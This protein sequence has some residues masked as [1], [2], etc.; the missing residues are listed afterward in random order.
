[1]KVWLVT[2]A[3]QLPIKTGLHDR[4]HRTGLIAYYLSEHKHEITWWTS[5]FNHFKKKF[6]FNEDTTV[7]LKENLRVNLIHGYGY[8]KNLSYARLRDHQW[9]AKK[10]SR[11]IRIETVRP[12]IIVASLPTIELCLES[13][14]FGREFG[15]PVVL[16][17]RDMWP[18]IF[19]F[20]APQI[21]RPLARLILSPLFYRS[22]L[23]CTGATAIIGITEAFVEWGLKSGKR[24]RTVLDRSFPHCYTS[25]LP[26]PEAIMKA[27]MYWDRFDIKSNS[28]EFIACFIGSINR[29]LDLAPI[30]NAANLIDKNKCNFVRFVICGSGDR[31]EYYK[32]LAGH[33]P[34]ILFP[35]W[36]DAA[37]IYVLLQR[38]SVGID[39]LPNRYD[40]T[41]TINN[42]AVEY[43]SAGLPV[44]STPINSLLANTLAKEQCGLSY[45]SGSAE[46]LAN[47]LLQL[48]NDKPRL[49]KLSQNSLRF[50]NERFLAEIVNE[51]MML[52]LEDCIQSFTNATI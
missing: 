20:I 8:K 14:K 36:V 44:I 10:F 32:K 41:S 3:E 48:E 21:I 23:A 7:Y 13:V 30:I 47:I 38:S 6:I 34:N 27:E 5:T 35:G 24:Q 37:A 52:H 29:T 9:I 33:N 26:S 51:K 22:Y 42:K 1:M 11:A 15:I 17:M 50:F 31:L 43:M 4:L 12:D 40:F 16:D 18:D 39:P 28:P 25:S 49:Q 2:M 19:L 45:N 46:E